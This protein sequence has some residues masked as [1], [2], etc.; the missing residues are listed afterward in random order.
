MAGR[1]SEAEGFQTDALEQARALK[2]RRYE[3]VILGQC[4][5]VALSRA[6]R[7][8]AL[9]LARAAREISDET[10]PGFI[11][12]AINGLIA[13][14]SDAREERE[15]ALAA[16]EAVLAKGAVGHNH[17]WFRRYAIERALIDEN[18]TEAERQSDA[19]IQRTADEPL[20]YA[21][22]VATRGHV[23]AR[24]GRGNATE[25]DEKKLE[26]ALAVAANADMRVDAL[27][28]ALRRM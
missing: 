13:L 23:L 1:Y 14:T 22:C 6:G 12:P 2:A 27:S 15:A 26:E 11:G 28:A 7:A 4:A 8:E 17:F 21:L 20:A 3:A 5:E 18:W 19:L 9:A 24:R 10:G 25:A 16:A